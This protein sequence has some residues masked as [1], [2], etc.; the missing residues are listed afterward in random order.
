VAADKQRRTVC[1]SHAPGHAVHWIQATHS[2]DTPRSPRLGHVTAIDRGVITVEFD[3][4]TGRYRN[5][6]LRVLRAYLKTYGT[7][8]I[9]DEGWSILRIPPGTNAHSFYAVR[10]DLHAYVSCKR[11]AGGSWPGMLPNLDN[12][13][14]RETRRPT[15]NNG[16]ITSS[17]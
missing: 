8:V 7:A 2:L 13:D 15:H 11:I 10:D 12:P 4:H 6:L 5:H 9:V 14:G 1:R 16:P 17:L 3:G